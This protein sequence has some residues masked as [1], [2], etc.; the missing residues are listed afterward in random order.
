MRELLWALSNQKKTPKLRGEDFEPPPAAGK[1]EN[2]H[3][4]TADAAETNHGARS[5]QATAW[6]D[7]G[8]RTHRHRFWRENAQRHA[9]QGR[10]YLNQAIGTGRRPNQRS[11]DVRGGVS[12]LWKSCHFGTT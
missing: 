7:P 3:R 10:L 1:P 2:R 12:R 8:T 4:R 9:Q 11:C 6:A 5:V